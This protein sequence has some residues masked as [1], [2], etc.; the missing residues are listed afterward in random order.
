ME[1][2]K[3]LEQEMEESLVEFNSNKDWELFVHG[4]LIGFMQANG[5]EVVSVDTKKGQKAKIRRGKSGEWKV[6]VVFQET[7]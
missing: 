3:T 2:N 4:K 5:I 6:E 7:L 1:Y